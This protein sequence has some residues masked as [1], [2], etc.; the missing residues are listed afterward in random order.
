MKGKE[1]KR[2][3]KYFDRILTRTRNQWQTYEPS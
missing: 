3:I 1:T 2:K